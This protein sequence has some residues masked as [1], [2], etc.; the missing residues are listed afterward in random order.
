MYSALEAQ[1]FILQ[2]DAH[3]MC[4]KLCKAVLDHFKVTQRDLRGR[5]AYP[6]LN[7]AHNHLGGA[8]NV[9]ISMHM[10]YFCLFMFCHNA[11]YKFCLTIFTHP[12]YV[13]CLY[14]SRMK[15]TQLSLLQMV[16]KTTL[17][18]MKAG[19]ICLCKRLIGTH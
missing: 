19:H 11:A 1:C 10:L 15:Q 4:H 9:G 7:M 6:K 12:Y 18:R 5:M 17:Y 13:D 14:L 8:V 16:Q 3:T 2:Q